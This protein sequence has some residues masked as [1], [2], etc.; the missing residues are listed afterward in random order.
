MSKQGRRWWDMSKPNPKK[1]EQ[2]KKRLEAYRKTI[3]ERREAQLGELEL[4]NRP[5]FI[6]LPEDWMRHKHFNT[7]SMEKG[8][9]KLV[10]Q[11]D[12]QHVFDVVEPKKIRKELRQGPY[13]IEL[14][15][16]KEVEKPLDDDELD[17]ILPV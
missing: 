15:N 1:E 8:L 11:L 13:G 5:Y 2:Q 6:P 14:I 9:I 10:K 12:K 7:G 4:Q 3:A 16:K 17:A